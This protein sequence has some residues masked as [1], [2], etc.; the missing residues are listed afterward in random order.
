MKD[1]RGAAL[2]EFAISALLVFAL[3][4]GII[5]FGWAFSQNLDVRHG[6]REASRLVAVN[7][8]PVSA[9]TPAEQAEDIIDEV[10]SRMDGG[11]GTRVTLRLTTAGQAGDRAEVE[12]E[13]TLQTLTGFYDALL[14][15]KT[16]RST[17]DTRIEV[18]STWNGV[19]P[20]TTR[21]K[22]CGT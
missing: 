20:P 11:S 19:T 17:V 6:A 21:T 12:V 2:V 9:A 5:E 16:L 13:R 18:D 3:V 4:F 10:C 1:E 8:R 14:A 7:Y 15:G 22:V